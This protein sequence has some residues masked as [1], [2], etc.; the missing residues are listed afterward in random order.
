MLVG[1]KLPMGRSG[2]MLEEATGC[3][4]APWSL[5]SKPQ[6]GQSGSAWLVSFVEVGGLR[7]VRML[8]GLSVLLASLRHLITGFKDTC[9][10]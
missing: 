7:M 2:M 4:Q 8:R 6:G 1:R 5:Y 10:V 9:C 3:C